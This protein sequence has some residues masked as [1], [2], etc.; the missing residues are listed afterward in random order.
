MYRS[1]ALARR[2]VRHSALRAARSGCV[3]IRQLALI[4]P[5]KH[6]LY[7]IIRNWYWLRIIGISIENGLNTHKTGKFLKGRYKNCG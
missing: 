7:H 1:L 6:P 4:V 2:A 5:N 3:V